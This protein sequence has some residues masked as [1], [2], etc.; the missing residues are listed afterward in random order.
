LLT[1]RGAKAGANTTTAPSNTGASTRGGTARGGSEPPSTRGG[2]TGRG[3]GGRGGDEKVVENLFNAL[4][5]GNAFSKQAR[6]RG[7]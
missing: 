2:A 5:G 3:R 7:K 4:E 1:P 6:G